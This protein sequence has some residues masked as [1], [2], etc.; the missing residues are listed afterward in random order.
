ADSGTYVL[1]MMTSNGSLIPSVRVKMIWGV[2]L[3][4]TALVLLY[5]GGL[6][7]LQNTMIIVAFPFSLVIALMTLSLIKA[8]N[9][10][11]RELGIGQVKLK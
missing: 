5:S 6:Q 9:A 10:E 1:G 4:V 8:V 7:A 3:S 11:A 2:F